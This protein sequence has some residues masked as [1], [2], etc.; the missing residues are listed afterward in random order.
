MMG[1]ESEQVKV[2]KKCSFSEINKFFNFFRFP[3]IEKLKK[4]CNPSLK[5]DNRFVIF[6]LCGRNVLRILRITRSL[7]FQ[8]IYLLDQI[9]WNKGE[10]K[11]MLST[12]LFS[13][14]SMIELHNFWFKISLNSSFDFSFILISYSKLTI[15]DLNSS[16]LSTLSYFAFNN[17]CPNPTPNIAA[18]TVAKDPK[19][20][21]LIQKN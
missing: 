3:Q 19:F 18:T 2:V 21:D 1:C 13:Y 6:V 8:I 7:D 17:A 16:Y 9:C 4:D 11:S 15:S 5:H 14:S 20:D 10:S 12:L